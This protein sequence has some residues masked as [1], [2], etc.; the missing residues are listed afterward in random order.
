[1]VRSGSHRGWMRNNGYGLLLTPH[2]LID[3]LLN[4]WFCLKQPLARK[5]CDWIRICF[6][7]DH[8]QR[9]DRMILSETSVL[10]PPASGEG[11]RNLVPGN[12]LGLVISDGQTTPLDV[13]VVSRS[14]RL[15][16][17]TTLAQRLR[18]D[19]A[20]VSREREVADKAC[21]NRSY[22]SASTLL[23]FF[24]ARTNFFLLPLF[25]LSSR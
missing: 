25:A 24:I 18:T 6:L 22:S 1:L 4:L 9:A 3:R 19:L 15:L 20:C 5:N 13:A 23:T 14:S 16:V 21:Y 12:L 2:E 11:T 8:R 17:S 7:A 10:L